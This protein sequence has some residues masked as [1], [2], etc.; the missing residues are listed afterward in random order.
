ILPPWFLGFILLKF[1]EFIITSKLTR[2]D[3]YVTSKN[4]FVFDK[5]GRIVSAM[6]FVVPG[7]ACVFQILTPEIAKNLIN[8][9]IYMVLSGGILSSY[10]R[11]INCFKSTIPN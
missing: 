2:R 7:A 4:V 8:T 11:I 3:S 6:F 10:L 5:I 1:I 9:I